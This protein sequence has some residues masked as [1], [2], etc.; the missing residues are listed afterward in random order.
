M[1]VKC[2]MSHILPLGEGR[3]RA[4]TAGQ[5]YDVDE[6]YEALFFEPVDKSDQPDAEQAAE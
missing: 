4:F 6:D 5:E 1:R 2:I 3:F